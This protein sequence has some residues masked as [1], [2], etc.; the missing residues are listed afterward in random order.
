MD[1]E[2]NQ[3][4][5]PTGRP[6]ATELSSEDAGASKLWAVYVKEAEK[7]DTALVES[8][9]DDMDGMLVFAGL[10][11][12][13]L[14]TFLGASYGLLQPDSGDTTVQLLTQ[15]SQQLAGNTTAFNPDP[16]QS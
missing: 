13:V 16:F 4:Q 1:P 5:Q 3:V 2:K 10:F 12:G 15:I 6:K 7:Y 9:K 8:W 14:S 11:S